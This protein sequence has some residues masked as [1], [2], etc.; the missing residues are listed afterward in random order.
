MKTIQINLNKIPI[1]YHPFINHVI[2]QCETNGIRLFLSKERK[3]AFNKS[4][5]SFCNGYF[6][7]GELELVTACGQPFDAWFSVFIHESSHMDQWLEKDPI[8]TSGEISGV[9]SSDILELWIQNHIELNKKQK[10]KIINSAL[11][12]E[13][14]CERRTIK[15]IKQWNL[16]MNVELY[17]QRANAY[18]WFYHYMGI[19]R[20]WYT[21]GY[22]PYNIPKIVTN[23]PT[24]LNGSYLTIPPHIK[25]IFK[26]YMEF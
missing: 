12:V 7:D 3:V 2:E 18:V 13:L 17:A 4:G 20:K 21:I 24:D 5:D 19:V 15:K 14:D 25:T 26:R 8:W 1:Q 23:M 22:E 9:E 6:C 10:E 16:P 11:Q